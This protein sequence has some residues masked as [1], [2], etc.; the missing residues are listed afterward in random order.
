LEAEPGLVPGGAFS[1]AMHCE[2]ELTAGDSHSSFVES[3]AGD[4]KTRDRLL[5]ACL[6]T[7]V[8]CAVTAEIHALSH[9]CDGERTRLEEWFAAS[10][11]NAFR[12][13]SGCCFAGWLPR[14]HAR[15]ERGSGECKC[16][17]AL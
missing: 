6:A 2:T 13:A 5:F 15:E 7:V 8:L 14:L 3:I 17:C 11:P 1:E 12:N 10:M 9:P 4:V 16:R